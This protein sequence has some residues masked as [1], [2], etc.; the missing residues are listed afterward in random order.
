VEKEVLFEPCQSKIKDEMEPGIDATHQ[1]G[2]FGKNGTRVGAR[3][4]DQEAQRLLIK[5][6]GSIKRLP[7]NGKK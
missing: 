3:H 2:L 4:G 5:V 7:C 1:N 6:E